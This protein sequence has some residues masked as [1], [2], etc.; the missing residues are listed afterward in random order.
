MLLAAGCHSG[1]SL[2]G[3]YTGFDAGKPAGI[4]MEITEKNGQYSMAE[5]EGEKPRPLD[6]P[7]TPFTAEDFRSYF[8]ELPP[9]DF[10]GIQ[11]SML[12]FVKVP[13]GWSDHTHSFKTASGY[14]L[15]LPI[16]AFEMR[17][18]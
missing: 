1:S 16:G 14:I 13:E 12:A 17:K 7:V 5:L 18:D 9:A 8:G 4:G 10:N 3:K 6:G 15:L 2:V 11:G